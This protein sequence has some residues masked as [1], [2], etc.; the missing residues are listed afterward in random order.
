MLLV[1]AGLLHWLSHLRHPERTLPEGPLRQCHE[2]YDHRSDASLG[3]PRCTSIIGPGRVPAQPMARPGQRARAGC[4]RDGRRHQ[5]GHSRVGLVRR[6]EIREEGRPGQQSPPR[7]SIIYHLEGWGPRRG[8]LAGHGQPWRRL[9]LP[10]LPCVGAFDRGVLP[11]VPSQVCQSAEHRVEGR[12]ADGD[13]RNLH[14]RG[15]H[16]QGV[17]VGLEPDPS[18]LLERRL[19]KREAL[20]PCK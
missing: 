2:C 19:S 13:Q 18:P 12:Q 6:H 1:L 16:A 9:L 15:H 5:D 3:E 14:H 17:D 4:L 20:S 11:E 8:D 7:V 10:A